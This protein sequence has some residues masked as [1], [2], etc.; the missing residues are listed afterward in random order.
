MAFVTKEGSKYVVHH[1]VTG[2]NLSSHSSRSESEAE[3]DRLHRKNKPK[4]TNK[5]ASA[6]ARD[7]ARDKKESQLDAFRVAT[8]AQNA[9]NEMGKKQMKKG[10]K[11]KNTVA[12]DNGKGIF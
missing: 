11:N 7:A 9:R 5:G 4:A 1:G 2:E 6:K 3:R 12:D 8:E 10:K